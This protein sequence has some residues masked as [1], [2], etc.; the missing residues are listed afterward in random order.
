MEREENYAPDS[1]NVID[2]EDSLQSEV[3]REN[4]DPS[5]TV[6]DM[7]DS[8]NDE[9]VEVMESNNADELQENFF[10][11]VD[12]YDTPS[13]DSS[14]H[15]DSGQDMYERS[16][17]VDEY[18]SGSDETDHH[19]EE[20]DIFEITES[21]EIPDESH[22]D[23]VGTDSEASGN[24]DFVQSEESPDKEFETIGQQEEV[25]NHDD[26][27]DLMSFEAEKDDGA[28]PDSTDLP[29]YE[30]ANSDVRLIDDDT[31]SLDREVQM[32]S[33][34]ISDDGFSL[35]DIFVS[36]GLNDTAGISEETG[37]GADI[38]QETDVSEHESL[39]HADSEQF[40]SVDSIL[41]DF[42]K[43]AD[44]TTPDVEL[45]DVALGLM[46][47]D[48]VQN[49]FIQDDLTEDNLIQTDPILDDLSGNDSLLTPEFAQAETGFNDSAASS[50]YEA[51]QFEEMTAS[52]FSTDEI[53]VP[54]VSEI[55]SE[56][57]GDDLTSVSADISQDM[58]N[59][60][61]TDVDTSISDVLND[62]FDSN[63]ADI[64]AGSI[65][66]PDAG[67]PDMTMDIASQIDSS[68]MN[69][70]EDISYVE[71]AGNDFAIEDNDASWDSVDSS[72][73]S[74]D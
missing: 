47:D 38:V 10:D 26:Q 52:V 51:P 35:Q 58:L 22:T 39:D 12:S 48:L 30:E 68:T 53:E 29:S 20:S 28:F 64:D 17:E 70:A 65:E 32:D 73:A 16:D 44:S 31:N 41:D 1:E 62:Y 25:F 67:L 55:L 63:I 37:Q 42:L 59:S 9:A 21:L 11:T 60:T 14:S 49:D 5:D 34:D 43:G 56:V 23:S 40:D 50:E 8:T 4:A 36:D 66:P 45:P 54:D 19:E 27:T 3:A 46:Q 71:A 33:A 69:A 57:F 7:S 24:F 61:G 2:H 18:H 72:C 15:S 6:Y 13:E 74:L